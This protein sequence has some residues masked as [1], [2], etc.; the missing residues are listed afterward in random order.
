MSPLRGAVALRVE[1]LSKRIVSAAPLRAAIPR[2]GS[3]PPPALAGA[4]GGAG[5]LPFGPCRFARQRSD[6]GCAFI[7]VPKSQVRPA[8]PADDDSGPFPCPGI[9]GFVS[10]T[11][12][13]NEPA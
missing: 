13:V 10:F 4:Q 5:L 7:A 1:P 11:L 3:P 12:R 9:A 2:A 8:V 6:Q